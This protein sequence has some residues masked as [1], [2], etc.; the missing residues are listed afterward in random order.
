VLTNGS[1]FLIWICYTYEDTCFSLN[2]EIG[3]VL[4]VGCKVSVL[5]L[6]L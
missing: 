2:E 3:E 6:V 4:H 1:K 5:E